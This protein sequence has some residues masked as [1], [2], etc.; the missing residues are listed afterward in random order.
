MFHKLIFSP[1]KQVFEGTRLGEEFGFWL[2]GNDGN[3]LRRTDD[4]PVLPR[5]ILA[6][7]F[8]DRALEH[9]RQ[10][11]HLEKLLEPGGVGR[12]FRLASEDFDS[13]LVDI[14]GYYQKQVAWISHTA[15]LDSISIMNCPP[16][17]MVST[18][19]YELDG[20]EPMDALTMGRKDTYEAERDR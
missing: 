15:G 3:Y 6:Y 17:A 4:A 20:E 8:L 14:G 12:I 18:Y 10:S 2:I 7:A 5:A 9:K 16:L 1:L 19:Y 13:L 11:V